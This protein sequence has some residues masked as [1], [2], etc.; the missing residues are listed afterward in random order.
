[1]N[2]NCTSVLP[3]I[4]GIDLKEES[5]GLRDVFLLSHSSDP[6]CLQCLNTVLMPHHHPGLCNSP[7]NL[8]KKLPIPSLC[9]LLSMG[10]LSA[11]TCSFSCFH[12]VI[13]Q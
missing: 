2:G 8:K 6:S 1:M 12:E 13:L 10:F 4:I 9:L 5:L 3:A 11:L 7:S